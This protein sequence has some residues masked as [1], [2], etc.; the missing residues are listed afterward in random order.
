MSIVRAAVVQDSPIVFD[1]KATIE[2]VR[3]LVK[4]A[5][6]QEAEMVLF[7]EAFV[8]AYPKGLDFGARIGMRFPRDERISAG[9]LKALLRFR[10]RPQTFWERQPKKTRSI[11]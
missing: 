3:N 4:E 7:P 9:I 8:S 5:A 2:K 6:S 10:A 1:R 11:W